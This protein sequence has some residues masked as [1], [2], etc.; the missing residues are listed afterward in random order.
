MIWFSRTA[1]ILI[2]GASSAIVGPVLGVLGFFVTAGVAAH[3]AR[4]F[5]P[6]NML[7]A[8]GAGVFFFS[9]PSAVAGALL[10]LMMTKRMESARPAA[11]HLYGIRYGALIGIAVTLSGLALMTGG[12]VLRADWLK[13]I[14]GTPAST[15]AVYIVFGMVIGAAMGLL[16]GTVLLKF[17]RPPR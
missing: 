17:Y 9:L 16:L 13:T 3:S 2:L 11:V 6:A 14:S 5:E 12:A 10:T 15:Y 1:W 4:I 7:L 8:C